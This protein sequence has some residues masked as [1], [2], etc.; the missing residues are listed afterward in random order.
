MLEVL[1]EYIMDG[2]NTILDLF[3]VVSFTYF[4]K[5]QFILILLI[6]QIYIFTLQ[7]CILYNHQKVIN[8]RFTSSNK[9]F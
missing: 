8:Q 4:N 2:E 6:S 1:S 7:K 5:D 3:N 9:K